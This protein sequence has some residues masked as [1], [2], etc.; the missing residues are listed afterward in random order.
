MVLKVKLVKTSIRLGH[1]PSNYFRLNQ[2]QIT[3][4]LNSR[5]NEQKINTTRSDTLALFWKDIL[6]RN[7][8]SIQ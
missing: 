1:W 7:F 2:K 5:I 6:T 4:H 3:K 8:I